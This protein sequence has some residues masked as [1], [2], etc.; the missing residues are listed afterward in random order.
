MEGFNAWWSLKG[1]NA[2]WSLKDFNAWW[3]LKGSNV[4]WPLKGEGETSFSPH[5]TFPP[6]KFYLN[7]FFPIDLKVLL[8]HGSRLLLYAFPFFSLT[9][10]LQPRILMYQIFFTFIIELI[11]IKDFFSFP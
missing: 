1:S 6:N 9:Y 3:P 5:F 8:Y 7:L 2:W 11:L 10:K 4:W